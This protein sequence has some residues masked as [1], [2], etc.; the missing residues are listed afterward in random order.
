MT[1]QHKPYRLTIRFDERTWQRLH[2]RAAAEGL[3][4]STLIREDLA[5]ASKR[6][7]PPTPS[8]SGLSIRWPDEAPAPAPADGGEGVSNPCVTP[9]DTPTSVTHPQLADPTALT[10]DTANV[11]QPPLKGGL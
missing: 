11:C 10:P 8:T 4:V 9:P 6:W 3:P 1:H 5:A 2:Y 7:R